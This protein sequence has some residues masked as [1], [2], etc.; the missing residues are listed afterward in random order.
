MSLSGVCTSLLLWNPCAFVS[1]PIDVLTR[2]M[3]ERPTAASAVVAT[4]ERDVVVVGPISKSVLVM[5]APGAVWALGAGRWQHAKDRE[6][7][8]T[9]A[10][11]GRAATPWEGRGLLPQTD[12]KHRLRHLGSG[13]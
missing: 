10:P 11:D 13:S 8:R 2:P 3:A 9:S 4:A 12:V 7:G 5:A 6:P 1:T